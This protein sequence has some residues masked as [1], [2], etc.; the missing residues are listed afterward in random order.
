MSNKVI[1]F[2]KAVQQSKEQEAFDSTL[3]PTPNI[4]D[5]IDYWLHQVEEFPEETPVGVASSIQVGTQQFVPAKAL[6]ILED[7][8]G[9]LLCLYHTEYLDTVKRVFGITDE[10]PEK[11]T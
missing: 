11:E 6:I 2:S 1:N 9:S 8:A 7:E 5:Y 10:E 3:D 4:I